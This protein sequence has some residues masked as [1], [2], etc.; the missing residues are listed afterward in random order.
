MAHHLDKARTAI[1][2]NHGRLP[3]DHPVELTMASGAGPAQTLAPAQLIGGRRHRVGVAHP[4]APAEADSSLVAKEDEILNQDAQRTLIRQELALQLASRDS[5]FSNRRRQ[6]DAHT[7]S[8]PRHQA[9]A[10]FTQRLEPRG[11]SGHGARH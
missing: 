10:K 6:F 11:R 3:P 7:A 8:I 1:S 5:R 9:R 4:S 2:L